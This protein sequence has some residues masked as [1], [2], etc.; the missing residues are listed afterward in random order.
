MV[1]DSG[2]VGAGARTGCDSLRALL[3]AELPALP[4]GA[5]VIAISATPDAA[6]YA[7]LLDVQRAGHPTWLLVIGEAAPVAVPDSLRCTW[8]GGRAAY[9]AL[10][11][12][13]LE[14]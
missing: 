6:T 11:E 10:A 5:A 8:I 13:E 3:R 4:F 9:A 14:R 2:R 1:C 12:L 7:T